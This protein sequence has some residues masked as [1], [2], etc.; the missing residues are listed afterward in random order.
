[1]P[2][3]NLTLRPHLCRPRRPRPALRIRTAATH[4]PRHRLHRLH[5]ARLP[6]PLGHTQQRHRGLQLPAG[7]RA[8][9]RRARALARSHASQCRRRGFQPHE[10]SPAP[11]SPLLCVGGDSVGGD[12]SDLSAAMISIQQRLCH[13]PRLIYP[14]RAGFALT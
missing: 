3:S 9:G 1:L 5:L 10:E 12:H 4:A 14:A 7:P 2:N 13:W 8:S 11:A 6:A